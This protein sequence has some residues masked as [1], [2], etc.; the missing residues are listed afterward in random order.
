M[1]W[2]R[3]G[4]TLVAVPA[5]EEVLLF[6]G[7]TAAGFSSEAFKIK[8]VV[9]EVS[10]FEYV[11]VTAVATPSEMEPRYAHSSFSDGTSIFVFGGT[12]ADEVGGLAELWK[13]HVGDKTWKKAPMSLK[14]FENGAGIIK[15]GFFTN[16]G[17]RPFDGVADKNTYLVYH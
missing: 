1:G 9:H 3:R 12:N 10:G 14:R 15:G 13:Y 4:H 7:Y 8:P 2:G 16:G 11:E 6:G 5:T 17:T